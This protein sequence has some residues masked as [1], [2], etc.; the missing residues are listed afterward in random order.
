MQSKWKIVLIVPYYG[1]FPNYF[2]LFLKSCEFNRSVNWLIFSDNSYDSL[3]PNVNLVKMSLNELEALISNKLEKNV[4][5]P[6]PYKLC[7][8]KPAYGFIFSDYIK[9]FDFWGHCDLDMIFGDIR[10][11]ITDDILE[12]YDKIL[13]HGHFT[14]YRNNETVNR[15][16][17]LTAPNE[18]P[19]YDVINI[20]ETM[21]FDEIGIVNILKYHGIEQYECNCFID[22]LPQYPGFR[23]PKRFGEKNYRNQVFYW[24]QGK[25]FKSWKSRGAVYEKEY[26]Y[27]HIQKR[28]FRKH[29]IDISVSD[30]FY[31]TPNGFVDIKTEDISQYY[32]PNWNHFLTYYYRRYTNVTPIKVKR[33]L[34]KILSGIKIVK[35]RGE[36]K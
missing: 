28:L 29:I 11:F 3:P 10:R 31:I 21:Y 1:R 32:K 23:V 22:I 25:V 7:D 26:M 15:Y 27:I 9:E 2:D 18:M 16:F 34:K 12:K 33:K 35:S 19:F 14:L 30:G 6:H 13:T 17:L 8:F 5:L 4:E 24:K 20:K 36:E